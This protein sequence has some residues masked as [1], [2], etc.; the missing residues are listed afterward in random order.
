VDAQARAE[1]A[2][3]QPVHR[4]ADGLAGDV[5]ARLLEAADGRVQIHRA[6]PAAEVRVRPIREVLDVERARADQVAR[7]GVDV[8]L[9]GPVAVDLGV[10][11]APAVEPG[12]GLDADE[13]PLLVRARVDEER[14]DARDLHRA[15]AQRAPSRARAAGGSGPRSAAAAAYSS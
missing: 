3:E 10:A 7:Q 9:D 8:G 6:A 4:L 1:R 2:A 11:L 15:S 5:P 14:A 13:E 12:V